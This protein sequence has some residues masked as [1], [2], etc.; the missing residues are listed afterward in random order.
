MIQCFVL[1]A[2]LHRNDNWDC[3]V[4]L[5]WSS[6]RVLVLVLQSCVPL[7][8]RPQT[9]LQGSERTLSVGTRATVT[10]GLTIRSGTLRV[11]YAPAVRLAANRELH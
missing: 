9:H 10:A 1:S 7:R 11:R 3:E 2:S 5:R 4:L 8:A 6:G